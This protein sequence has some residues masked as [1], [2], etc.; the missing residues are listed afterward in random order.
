M[1][2]SVRRTSFRNIGLSLFVVL[3]AVESAALAQTVPTRRH[4]Y[5]YP[6]QTTSVVLAPTTAT[7]TGNSQLVQALKSAQRLLA[8]ANRNYDG[9]RASAAQEVRKAMAALGYRPK[10]AQAGSTLNP[11]AVAG[12]AAIRKSQANSDAQLSQARQILQGAL[13]QTNAS[14]P[15]ASTHLKAAIVHINAALSIK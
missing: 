11:G 8:T 7:S 10:K 9:H 15:K 13:M 5:T 3:V 4:H 2:L 12:Q 14:R 6:Q 1:G